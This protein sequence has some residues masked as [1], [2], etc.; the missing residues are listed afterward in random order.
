VTLL[1]KT[2][3]DWQHG[4]AGVTMDPVFARSEVFP[5]RAVV[6][7]VTSFARRF[8]WHVR[9]LGFN[10]LVRA[11]DRLESLAILAAV[12][13]ALFATPLTAHVGT[14]MH[15]SGMR[16]VDQQSRSRH[17]VEAVA[18]ERASLSADFD[19]PSYVRA[20]WREGT[21]LRTERVITPA[22][23]NAGEPISIWLDNTGNV[24]AA[25]LSP[26]DATL[27]AVV[28]AA[29][30]WVTIATC[31]ALLAYAVRVGLDRARG[32]EWDRELALL[33]HN[34]DGWANRHV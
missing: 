24:V 9:A 27:S 19:G 23:V 4:D 26:D 29:A 5:G 6:I 12:I 2:S 14:Q 28:A 18:L 34:D 11:T 33:T 16:T 1:A 7:G 25:P 3:L 17:P 8:S 20:Q 13:A 31:F 15:D 21:R 22:T 10:P 32:R 30:L